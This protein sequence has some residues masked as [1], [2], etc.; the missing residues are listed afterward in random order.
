MPSLPRFHLVVCSHS[1][2]IQ[3]LHRAEID[4]GNV[5]LIVELSIN[6]NLAPMFGQVGVRRPGAAGLLS[7]KA[8]ALSLAQQFDDIIAPV[9]LAAHPPVPAAAISNGVANLRQQDLGGKDV[10]L[11]A[12]VVDVASVWPVIGQADT[13]RVLWDLTDPPNFALGQLGDQLARWDGIGNDGWAGAFFYR[14]E[15]R[16]TAVA[17][18]EAKKAYE[19]VVKEYPG[20]KAVFA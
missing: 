17:V 9:L 8:T 1:W 6:S 15:R 16:R 19:A 4:A 18:S 20:M 10:V 5:A 13:F 12:N 2:A 7:P 11:M 3:H 14:D